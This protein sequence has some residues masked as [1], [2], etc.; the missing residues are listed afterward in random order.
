MIFHQPHNSGGRYN[1]NAFFYEAEAW[2]P[3]FHKNYELVYVVRGSIE[4]TV[5]T[6]SYSLNEGDFGMCL[7]YAVHSI[8]PKTD[9]KYWVM[10]FS[11][12]FVHTFGKQ[13]SRKK[14]LGFTFTCDNSVK[15]FLL[16][17]L[18]HAKAPSIYL[19]KACLYAAC[20]EFKKAILFEENKETQHI[21]T[22]CSFMEQKHTEDI[23]LKDLS[24]L[25]GYDYHYVSRYFH[26]MF[27]ISFTEFLNTYRLQTALALLED[28]SKKMINIAFESG[29]KSVR[30]FNYCFKKAMGMSPLEYKK[31]SR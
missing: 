26:S 29:F 13:I 15:E 2:E 30:N 28:D 23:S 11:E 4:C 18:I 16:C 25:L 17:N 31:A 7:P 24:Q 1:Y 22:I 14:A 10:V 19:L 8:Q 6:S 5:N 20:N 3:H 27:N 21:D 12:D 9:S